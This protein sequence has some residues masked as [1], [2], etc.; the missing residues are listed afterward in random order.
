MM[1]A[2]VLEQSAAVAALTLQQV[3]LQ[4]VVITDLLCHLVMCLQ[5][6]QTKL[7]TGMSCKC[8]HQQGC[9]VAR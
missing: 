5:Q 3:G 2:A 7:G 6:Q 4:L 8:R 9:S 1:H